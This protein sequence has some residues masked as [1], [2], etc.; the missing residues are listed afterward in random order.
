MCTLLCDPD[1]EERQKKLALLYLVGTLAMIVCGIICL[2]EPLHGP[3]HKTMCSA[4][5]A[6]VGG[7][8]LICFPL[9]LGLLACTFMRTNFLGRMWGAVHDVEFALMCG[10]RS[11]AEVKVVGTRLL[12]MLC[13]FPLTCECQPTTAAAPHLSA[14]TRPCSRRVLGMADGIFFG[15]NFPE[16]HQNLAWPEASCD[17]LSLGVRPLAICT[18]EEPDTCTSCRGL[19]LCDNITSTFPE[20]LPLDD[21]RAYP[22]PGRYNLDDAETVASTCNGLRFHADNKPSNCCPGFSDSYECNCSWDPCCWGN[23]DGGCDGCEQCSTCYTCGKFETNV[24]LSVECDLDQ[25]EVWISTDI[26]VGVEQTWATTVRVPH[27]RN[28]R[29]SSKSTI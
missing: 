8:A 13:S 3:E 19:R 28:T 26:T 25:R 22:V 17:V 24:C 2:D 5:K 29:C 6:P 16:I 7:I 23:T 20:E 21:E 15:W 27:P 10:A 14:C 1:S 4:A 9:A 18:T 12:V 11:V